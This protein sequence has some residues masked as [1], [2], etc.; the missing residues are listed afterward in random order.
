[1]F[2]I[3]HFLYFAV[4]VLYMIQKIENFCLRNYR[5]SNFFLLQKV[6][7]QEDTQKTPQSNSTTS[8][9]FHYVFIIKPNKILYIALLDRQYFSVTTQHFVSKFFLGHVKVTLKVRLTYLKD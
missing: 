7:K 5:L 3:F 1:M 6:S 2:K 4:V 8:G 9:K